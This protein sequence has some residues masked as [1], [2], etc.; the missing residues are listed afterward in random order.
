MKLGCMFCMHL[1]E[2]NIKYEIAG[3]GILQMDIQYDLHIK[4]AEIVTN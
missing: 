4:M 2:M 1:K 3:R